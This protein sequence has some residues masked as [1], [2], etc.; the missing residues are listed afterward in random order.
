VRGFPVVGGVERNLGCRVRVGY[1]LA[2]H[3][4]LPGPL[5][6]RPPRLDRL[7]GNQAMKVLSRLAPVVTAASV[8]Y[9]LVTRAIFSGGPQWI[10][11][12]L[13]A[14]ALA[15][16][17]RRTFRAGQFRVQADPGAGTLLSSGPYRL[18]RHPMYAAALLLVW[19]AVA[20]HPTPL[21]LGIGAV[22]SLFAAFRIVYEERTL[23]AHFADYAEYAR[24]TRRII[25]YVL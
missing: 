21:H 17:A 9:L 24:R 1:I 16:W 14:L 6:H 4:A 13:G 25:P 19:S 11:I 10:V 3:Q 7:K 12:Q 18:I 23:R 8:L 20:A 22:L 5:D 2:E 15:V